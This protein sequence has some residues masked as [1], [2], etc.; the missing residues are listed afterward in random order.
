MI[1]GN[2][3]SATDTIGAHRNRESK[4]NKLTTLYDD[5]DAACRNK[6]N[7]SYVQQ[8][9][10]VLPIIDSSEGRIDITARSQFISQCFHSLNESVTVDIISFG[11]FCDRMKVLYPNHVI[12]KNEFKIEKIL[13]NKPDG[14][15]IVQIFNVFE[16]YKKTTCALN[17]CFSEGKFRPARVEK[18]CYYQLF[19][20]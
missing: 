3:R 15:Y 20:I 18:L 17:D 12:I 4:K 2:K 13:K 14:T 8:K 6:K 10:L 19:N 1:T 11:D 5:I 9:K 16:I 7:S